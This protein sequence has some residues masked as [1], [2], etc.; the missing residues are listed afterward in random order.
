MDL[1][2][3]MILAKRKTFIKEFD[4][5]FRYSKKEAAG[6]E[7]SSDVRKNAKKK[8]KKKKKSNADH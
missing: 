3:S 2:K 5:Q 1:K 6:M 7:H 4:P 8:K